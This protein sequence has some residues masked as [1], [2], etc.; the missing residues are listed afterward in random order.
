MRTL[1]GI[2][3]KDLERESEILKYLP[4]IRKKQ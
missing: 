2:P 1:E 3:Q 4:G